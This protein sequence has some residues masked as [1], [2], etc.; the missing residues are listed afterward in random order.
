MTHPVQAFALLDP[1][2]RSFEPHAAHAAQEVAARQHARGLQGE[3]G[4][5]AREMFPQVPRAASIA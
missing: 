4:S 5:S 3:G 1:L 2:V